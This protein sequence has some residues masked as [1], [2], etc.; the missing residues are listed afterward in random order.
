MDAA[1]LSRCCRVPLPELQSQEHWGY[2]GLYSLPS[3]LVETQAWLF[4]AHLW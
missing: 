2:F 1:Q 3:V 4:F